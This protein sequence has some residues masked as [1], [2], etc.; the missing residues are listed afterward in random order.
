[1]KRERGALYFLVVVT[2]LVLP[3]AMSLTWYRISGD[4]AMQ[5][6][7]LN[8]NAARRFFGLPGSDVEAII[9]WDAAQA[10]RLTP[11]MLE[12]ALVTGFAAKGVGVKTIFRPS[13]TG[14][15][16]SYKVGYSTFGPYPRSRAAEGITPAVDAFRMKHP[17]K[18]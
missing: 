4:P 2:L 10:G 5:P 8:A 13:T 15:A 16:V 12:Q 9:D 11:D 3:S 7:G 6:M 17:W 14:I 18:P 1:M